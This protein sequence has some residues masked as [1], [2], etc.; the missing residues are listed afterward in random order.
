[1]TE[2]DVYGSF[3]SIEEGMVEGYILDAEEPAQH[4]DGEFIVL[5]AV[6]VLAELLDHDFL[7]DGFDHG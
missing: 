1:M 5:D 6:D 7:D 4:F 2:S 3:E